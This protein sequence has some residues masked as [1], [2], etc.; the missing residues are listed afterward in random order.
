MEGPSSCESAV[1]IE[2]RRSSAL[3]CLKQGPHIY[4]KLLAPGSSFEL[5]N[6]RLPAF[7]SFQIGATRLTQRHPL[8]EISRCCVSDS[9]GARACHHPTDDISPARKEFQECASALAQ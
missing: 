1:V 3:N 8:Q 7:S 6:R 5:Q 2:R 9:V 4:E